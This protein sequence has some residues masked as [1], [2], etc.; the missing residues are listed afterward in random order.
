[1]LAKIHCSITK[2]ISK[3]NQFQR[4]QQPVFVRL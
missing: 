1:L 4:W 3:M 2:K